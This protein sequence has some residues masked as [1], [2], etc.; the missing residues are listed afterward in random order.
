MK[1]EFLANSR[2]ISASFGVTDCESE[3]DVK[4]HSSTLGEPGKGQGAACMW[5]M[6][7]TSKQ[8]CMEYGTNRQQRYEY[9]DLIVV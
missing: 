3:S 1:N 4:D 2:T 6:P 9:E 5:V 7:T 8:V